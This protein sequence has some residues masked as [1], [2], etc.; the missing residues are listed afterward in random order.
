MFGIQDQHGPDDDR[1]LGLAV[2]QQVTLRTSSGADHHGQIQAL[3]Q[4]FVDICTPTKTRVRLAS[5]ES[6]AWH[7]ERTG[8]HRG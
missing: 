5:L 4:Y 7:A 6:V 1:S 3:G 8:D 2:G